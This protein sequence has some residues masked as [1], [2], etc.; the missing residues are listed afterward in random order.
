MRWLTSGVIILVVS[1]FAHAQEVTAHLG[2][3][4]AHDT[5]NGQKVDTFGTGTLYPTNGIGGLFVDLGFTAILTRTIGAAVDLSWQGP[6]AIYAGI[7]YRPFFYSFDGVY[8]PA[9]TTTSQ[10]SPEIKAGIGAASLRFAPDEQQQC[11]NGPACQSSRHFQVHLAVA[12]RFYMSTHWFLR[13]A[14]DVHY[15]NDFSEFGSNWVQE[16]SLGFG[17][18][19]GRER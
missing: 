17:Y 15:V 16:Y 7:H 6:Q 19:I 2:F 18:G 13:P 11:V 5:S 1:S 12:G 8:Q 9:R 4:G 14:I 10:F 3:G